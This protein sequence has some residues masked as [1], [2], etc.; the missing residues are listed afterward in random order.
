MLNI[1]DKTV[2]KNLHNELRL[3]PYKVQIVQQLFPNDEMKIINFCLIL[4]CYEAHFH[5]CDVINKRNYHFLN[6]R[7]T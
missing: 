2:R 7:I 4:L 6:F 3:F 5:L 1:C